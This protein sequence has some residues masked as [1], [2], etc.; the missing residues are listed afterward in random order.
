MIETVMEKRVRCLDRQ[1]YRGEKKV[2][3]KG[4]I[5]KRKREDNCN[6]RMMEIKEEIVKM[7]DYDKENEQDRK[8]WNGMNMQIE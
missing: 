8:E 5:Q 4:E 3:K 1:D 7:K 2:D 6:G